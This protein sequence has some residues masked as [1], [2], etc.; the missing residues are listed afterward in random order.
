M[1]YF[2][3]NIA[4]NLWIIR[5]FAWYIKYLPARAPIGVL[6]LDHSG[7][8]SMPSQRYEVCACVLGLGGEERWAGE[9]AAEGEQSRPRVRAHPTFGQTCDGRR[10]RRDIR[11]ILARGFLAR[12]GR[13]CHCRRNRRLRRRRR[14]RRRRRGVGPEAEERP[15]LTRRAG[16][17][18]RQTMPVPTTKKL[19]HSSNVF[20][21]HYQG[22]D[23]I[24]HFFLSFAITMSWIQI[25]FRT[26]FDGYKLRHGLLC[27]SGQ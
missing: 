1:F 13:R 10:R 14:R 16:A 12:R 4:V 5:E 2:H 24:R 20:W 23:P 22:Q 25:Y 17:R 19:P 9:R 21:D 7:R 6:G 26:D 11:C 15:R 27:S 8:W 3:L 18:A